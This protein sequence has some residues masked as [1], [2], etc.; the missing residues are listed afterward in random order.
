MTTSSIA[1]L[2]KKL[3]GAAS[4]DGDSIYL[5]KLESC[6][7]GEALLLSWQHVYSAVADLVLQYRT[8]RYRTSLATKQQNARDDESLYAFLVDPETLKHLTSPFEPFQPPS[9]ESNTQFDRLTSAINVTPDNGTYDIVQIKSDALWLA[10]Q[11]K[12]NKAAALRIV[13]LEWQN[14]S[15][16]RLLWSGGDD[17][18]KSL[19]EQNESFQK[20][21]FFAK[22]SMISDSQMAAERTN[23]GF[24][25]NEERQ[26]R[27][28]RLYMAER[29]HVLR[30]SSLLIRH[31][32]EY[33]TLDGK[34]TS[35]LLL[36]G[37][38]LHSSICKTENRPATGEPTRVDNCIGDFT[39]ALKQR[40]NKLEAGSGWYAADGGNE[41]LERQ[42]RQS[43][44]DEMVPLLQL[45]FSVVSR[46]IPSSK[47]TLGY[48]TLLS[49]R[50]F[51]D[52]SSV[53][54]S[55]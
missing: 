27:L 4:A 51:F 30:T 36:I 19:E 47:A 43:Q 52:F 46:V 12:I 13:V 41:S 3:Q 37:R 40:V 5:S 48:M 38:H 18:D 45:M 16:A 24:V 39:G 21:S 9:T 2:R 55:Q 34:S 29:L 26:F 22:S 42:W 17:A 7:R 25:S 14:R 23:D 54:V 49:E 20:S 11:T 50:S 44:L 15:A 31:F 6:L 53:C 35:Q 1:D 10:D 8:Q 32:L 33:S 28:L